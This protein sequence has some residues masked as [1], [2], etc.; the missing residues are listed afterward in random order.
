MFEG[1]VYES[2]RNHLAR[3]VGSGAVLFLGNAEAPMNYPDNWYPFRQDSIFLYYWGHALPSLAALV[4]IDE[5]RHVLFADSP[6]VMDVIWS[7]EHP[8]AGEL[9]TQVNATE[10][11]PSSDLEKTLAGLRSRGCPIHFVPPYRA[12]TASMLENLLQLRAG[13]A[14]LHA[15]STL[16]RAIIA[17]RLIK[18]PREVKEI[19]FALIVTYAMHTGAMQMAKP[20]V[21]ERAVAGYVEAVAIGGGGRLAFPC[22][23]SKR[24]EV[25]HNHSYDNTLEEGD[26]VVHDSGAS[27]RLGYASDITRTFPVSGSFTPQQKAIYETVLTAQLVAIDAMKPGVSFKEV[28][29]QAARSLAS[30][31]K[32]LGLMRGDVDEAVAAGA[33]ALFFPHGLG[34]MMGLDVHD[35][36][37]LGEDLVGYD[38]EVKRADQFGLRYLRMGKSLQPGHVV[39]VEP[40]CYFIGALIDQWQA[41][42]KHREFICYDELDAWRTFGGVRIEDDVLVTEAGVR[43]LGTPIPKTI[44]EVEAA[45]RA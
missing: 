3:E 29:I 42:D 20:G 25:L 39:T 8:S 26:L 43:V 36:E 10:V 14:R 21:V 12:D 16:A 34:H 44:E 23:F 19:E 6:T 13:S 35:L 15:S 45:C 22:I 30:S 38:E 40:G 11:L 9:G 4:D 27:S 32:D 7:G 41:E 1:T 5:G 37:G 31:L 33:P 17:Q 2:R 24:G 28:H 18:E